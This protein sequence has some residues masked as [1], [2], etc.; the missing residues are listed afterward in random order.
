ML[1]KIHWYIKKNMQII[2]RVQ[3]GV[4]MEK[5]LLKVLKSL[6]EFHDTTQETWRES[7]CTLLTTNAL[8]KGS[9]LHHSQSQEVL[10]AGSRLQCEP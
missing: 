6:A 5:R 10:W 4:R 7:C 8:F 2:E 9:R 1:T 3:T